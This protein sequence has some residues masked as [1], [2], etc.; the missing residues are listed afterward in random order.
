MAT[1]HKI[2]DVFCEESYA[3]LAIHSSLEDHTLVF[4]LNKKLKTKLQRT[5]TDLDISENVGF[6][7]F[8]WKD[9]LNQRLW[10]LIKNAVQAEERSELFDLFRGEESGTV[11]HVI[12]EHKEV[13]YFLKIDQEERTVDEQIIKTVLEI[14]KVITAYPVDAN[15]LRSKQNLNF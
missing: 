5:K 7:V 15:S 12:P 14:P 4:T 6:P 3:L 10:T 1:T 9:E 2:L 13:D 11:Y 8:E